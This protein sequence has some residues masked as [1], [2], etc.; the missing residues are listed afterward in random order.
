MENLYFLLRGPLIWPYFGPTELCYQPAV[1]PAPWAGLM[2]LH[3][4]PWT[5]VL[6]VHTNIS[7]P[8]SWAFCSFLHLPP[9]SSS[10][11]LRTLLWRH[12]ASLVFCWSDDNDPSNNR[13]YYKKTITAIPRRDPFLP[14]G[15]FSFFCLICLRKAYLS[16]CSCRLKIDRYSSKGLPALSLLICTA[17]HLFRG[18]PCSRCWTRG[19]QWRGWGRVGSGRACGCATRGSSRRKQPGRRGG[20][21][22]TS[23]LSVGP[24]GPGKA[25][26]RV[27]W[28]RSRPKAGGV[29]PVSSRISSIIPSGSSIWPP[30]RG[31]TCAGTGSR[32][33]GRQWWRWWIFRSAVKTRINRWWVARPRQ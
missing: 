21:G 13:K 9:H 5:Q 31:P 8:I 1:A 17:W 12:W 2:L 20:E 26:I 27:T 4:L 18:W 22:R 16:F 14:W 28:G 23:G 15:I 7:P 33:W 32:R 10:Y 24:A 30:R 3:S 25:G 29:L 19:S 11:S 6:I